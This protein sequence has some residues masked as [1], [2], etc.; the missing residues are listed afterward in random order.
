MTDSGKINMTFEE[1]LKARRT[2]RGFLDK[3]VPRE[4]IQKAFELA[5]LSPSN[6][7]IQP[8]RV[9]VA[10]GATRDAIRNRLIELVT[11]GDI[12]SPD[13]DYPGKFDGVYRKRQVDCAVTLYKEMGIARD[14][15]EGRLKALLKNFE[16]FDAPHM[17]FICMEKEFPATIAVDIGLYA[18]TLMLAFTSLGISSCP[19]GAMRNH[20]Q[21][22][23][24]VFG[25]GDNLGVLFGIAFGYEDVSVPANNTR[26]GRAPVDEC[27]VFKD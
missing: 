2:V 18:Q 17:A 16:F 9:F 3:P 24:E 23:R 13:F 14:D 20:P 19:M 5:Q 15:H 10:S 27:V 12:G 25:F 8:W 6:S 11:S 21:V 7:N 26:V 1:T 22:S 4:T